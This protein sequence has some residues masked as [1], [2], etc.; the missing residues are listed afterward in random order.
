MLSH[1]FK[2]QS[3][4]KA[5]LKLALPIIAGQVGQII[6]NI[7]DNLM[8]GQLGAAQLA[9]VSLANALFIALMVIGM[10]ISFALPPLIAE[11]V[12]KQNEKGI[13]QFFKHSLLINFIYALI[14]IGIIEL[15]IP[16]MKHWKQE[17]AVVEFALPY[18]RISAISLIPF[19]LFQTFRTYSDGLSKTIPPM[20]AMISA[21]IVNVF[22][23]YAF[24]YGK[25]G[26]PALGV[27]GA[28]L[29]T[30]IAR[31]FM[32]CL[33]IIILYRSKK[34][35]RFIAEADFSKY[36]INKF[37][38]L[39]KIGIP[40]SLQGFFEVSAFGIAAVMAG[41]INKEAQAAH[42]IAINL[43]SI[44]FLICTGIAM[45]STIRVGNQL[46]LKNY[47]KL[48]NI[49]FASILQVVAFMSITSVVYILLRYFLPSLYINNE[50]VINIAAGLLVLASVFQIP[51]GVQVTAIGA[52]R[53]LQDVNI[54][55]IIT[56]VAYWLFALPISYFLAFN[57]PL[58]AAGIWI[59]LTIGLTCSAILMT[60]R[61]HKKS[62]SIQ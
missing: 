39:L 2:Y 47:Q 44:S 52:L 45:A 13:S 41:Q 43:A 46:G 54:P 35:W 26:A 11:A 17:A 30:L 20:I 4:F 42:Q 16:T 59:G 50:E 9:A 32:L 56:F 3:E 27:Q 49:G 57:T 31:I 38:H 37:I 40:T 8:V 48:R 6:V 58:K 55:T 19:M 61:F 23:N 22:G 14:A 15:L 21:N 34:I 1:F 62:I 28:A 25:F 33:L 29:G 36:Q 60:W 53:G 12:G 5:N 18:L 51:D 7:V 10:G 24:I